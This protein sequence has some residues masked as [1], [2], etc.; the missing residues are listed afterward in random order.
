M[1]LPYKR[2]RERALGLRPRAFFRTSIYFIYKQYSDYLCI[3]YAYYLSVI[4]V[5]KWK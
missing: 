4:E 1:I 2:L 3:E 5:I